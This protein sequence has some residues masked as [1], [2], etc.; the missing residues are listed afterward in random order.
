MRSLESVGPAWLYLR[1]SQPSASAGGR[2]ELLVLG[3]W[4]SS[5]SG[6]LMLFEPSA[7]WSDIQVRCFPGQRGSPLPVSQVSFPWQTQAPTPTAPS[8]SSAPSR[9]TG[10]F[11]FLAPSM[12]AAWQ[13]RRGCVLWEEGG[14][15]LD[16]LLWDN[17][18]PGAVH[19]FERKRK[20]LRGLREN[21]GGFCSSCSQLEF[22]RCVLHTCKKYIWEVLRNISDPNTACPRSRPHWPG[23]R[24]CSQAHLGLGE[25]LW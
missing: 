14:L 2:P 6:D 23:V 16:C 8:S 12:R 11:L 13:W 10:E 7:L 17:C 5:G 20:F 1:A 4:S 19:L 21:V 18:S 22:S 15:G 25:P 9:P 3:A 24:C